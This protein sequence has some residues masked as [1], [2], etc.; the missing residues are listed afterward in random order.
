MF[1]SDLYE[2]EWAAIPSKFHTGRLAMLNVELTL[3]GLQPLLPSLDCSFLLE[4]GLRFPR[5]YPNPPQPITLDFTLPNLTILSLTADQRGTVLSQGLGGLIAPKL[6]V[7]NLVD[8]LPQVTKGPAG[9]V[10]ASFPNLRSI[11]IDAAQSGLEQLGVLNETHLPALRILD[12]KNCPRKSVTGS[13][14]SHVATKLKET[15]AS[16]RELRI[17]APN[18]WTVLRNFVEPMEGLETLHLDMSATGGSEGYIPF[19]GRHPKRKTIGL[20][21][22]SHLGIT[23]SSHSGQAQ[24]MVKSI[25]AMLKDREEQNCTLKKLSVCN[26]DTLASVL[27]RELPNTSTLVEYRHTAYTRFQTINSN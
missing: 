14:W 8:L 15:L 22:L 4:L 19:L 21:N 20:P 5:D 2:K 10:R 23:V 25:I 26:L 18:Q 12:I 27:H 1:A 3:A 16:L 9:G 6:E 11:T 24:T 13:S 7:L 17:L